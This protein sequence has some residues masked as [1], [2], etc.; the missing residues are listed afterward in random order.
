[1]VIALRFFG[2][3]DVSD[4]SSENSRAFMVS[5]GLCAFAFWVVRGFRN[6]ALDPEVV[7]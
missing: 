1:V 5:L 4:S 6:V 7:G 2:A 3:G